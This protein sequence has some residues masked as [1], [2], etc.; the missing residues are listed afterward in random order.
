MYELL[1]LGIHVGTVVGVAL[2]L[3]D[4]VQLKADLFIYRKG[5]L[6]RIDPVR[7]WPPPPP[8]R[9]PAPPPRWMRGARQ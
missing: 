6:P 1:G 5:G 4:W 2:L 8:P 7:D 3:R 9:W